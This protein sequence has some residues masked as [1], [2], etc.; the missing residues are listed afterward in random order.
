MWLCLH[1]NFSACLQLY[2]AQMAGALFV[3]V[4]ALN[5]CLVN[6]IRGNVS[7]FEVKNHSNLP[8]MVVFSGY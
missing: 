4:F 1:I 3:K 2:S 8:G 6:N 5:L 7:S